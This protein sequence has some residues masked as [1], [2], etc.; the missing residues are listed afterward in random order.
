MAAGSKLKGTD[1]YFDPEFR[2]LLSLDPALEGWRDWAAQYWATELRTD[3][4]S[5]KTA[6]SAF[7]IHYLHGKGLHTMLPDVF[8]DKSTTLP[9]S[10]GALDYPLQIS[11][12]YANVK[13]DS[14]SDFLDWIL[15]EKFAQPDAE[16]HR[17]VPEH[18]ANPF[19]RR[20]TKQ[21]G[22]TSDLSFTHV[23]K[24][25][26][27]LEDWRSLAAEWLKEQKINIDMRR[28]ALDRF[29][30]HYIHSQDLERNFG[31][32]LLRDTEKPDMLKVLVDTK[33]EGKRALQAGEILANNIIS[34]FLDWVLVSRLGDPE[35]GEWDRSR[36]HNPVQ[37]LTKRGL[38]TNTQSDKASLSIRYIRELRGMLAQGP[39]FRDWTWAQTAND[40]GSTGG[41]WI[42]VDQKI[43][44]HN[45]LDCVFRKRDASKHEM[46]SKG[47]PAEV[48]EIWSPVRAVSLYLKLELPL[49]TMQVRMLDSGEADTYRYVHAPG[50]GGFVRN[51]GPL[52]NGSE[53]RPYQRGVCVK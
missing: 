18:L 19:P 33:R 48:W 25:D 34:D 10:D 43:I 21:H 50:G 17:V 45:D 3:K 2:F 47:Y 23:L 14:V 53:K 6:I 38:P 41:D 15:R 24:R 40:N 29:L 26:P 12:K 52:A 1:L 5:L 20:R 8:F 22:Q 31:R 42:V 39:N 32:F 44:V 27:K 4:S 37:H 13:H 7:L 11:K 30:V 28:N 36:F 16:G 46:K 35:T 9:A 51:F 49:R